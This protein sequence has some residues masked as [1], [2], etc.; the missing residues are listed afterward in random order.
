MYNCLVCV[1]RWQ[2]ILEIFRV[3][4]LQTVSCFVEF[5]SW[6]DFE[7]PRGSVEVVFSFICI[8]GCRWIVL[9]LDVL[10]CYRAILLVDP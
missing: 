9:G 10:L 8:W 3:A 2:F 1:V 4:C 5:A 7:L 6:V